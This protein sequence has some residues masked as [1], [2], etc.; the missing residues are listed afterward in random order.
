MRMVMRRAQGLT[1]ADQGKA[2]G[3]RHCGVLG[4]CCAA[5]ELEQQRA[6]E[7][8]QQ[9]ARQ[10]GLDLPSVAQDPVDVLPAGAQPST[11]GHMGV[12]AHQQACGTLLHAQHSSAQLQMCSTCVL[13]QTRPD[14]S[15]LCYQ[16]ALTGRRSCPGRSQSSRAAGRRHRMPCCQ[17]QQLLL[18][19]RRSPGCRGQAPCAAGHGLLTHLS[20][21]SCGHSPLP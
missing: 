16:S 15:L 10:L 12:S 17:A 5:K 7:L 19:P 8:R 14:A 3:C 6:Q 2:V 20:P 13:T 21:Q 4:G 11:A 1:D 18:P 9:A